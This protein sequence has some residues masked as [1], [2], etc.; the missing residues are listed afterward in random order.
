MKIKMSLLNYVIRPFR[1]IAGGKSL[2]IG[3][4]VLAVVSVSG[5]FTYTY[6]D[7]V[8]D[9]H[10][11]CKTTQTALWKH[12]FLV[13]GSWLVSVVVFYVTA[14]IVSKSKTRLVD[15]AGTFAVAKA[16]FILGAIIGLIPNMHLCLGADISTTSL[17]AALDLMRENIVWLLFGMVGVIFI[18]IWF[19]I[20]MYNAYSISANV[21]GKQGILSFI[22]ALLISEIGALVLIH[23]VL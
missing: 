16:P 15:L 6:F 5:Y 11:A 17:Q 3:I 18:A 22:A 8:L 2:I 1:Y 7:G 4:L 9:I 23:L 20:L 19:I 10:F 14:L 21:K 13:F 12:F